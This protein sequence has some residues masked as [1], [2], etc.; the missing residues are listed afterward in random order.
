MKK[1]PHQEFIENN[2]IDINSLPKMLQK[3][4]NGFDEL[5]NDLQHTTEHDRAQLV[6][7]LETLSHEIQEDLD[8]EFEDQLEN[9]DAEE[10]PTAVPKK[11]LAAKDIQ[12]EINKPVK[13]KD[14]KPSGN[15]AILEKMYAEKQ[16]TISPEQLIQ[17]GFKVPLDKKIIVGKY[18]LSRG[19]YDKCY[20]LIIAGK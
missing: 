7:K 6:D 19:K 2:L 20:Q 1:Y 4:I 5:E 10:E 18:S 14:V 3:R 12:V 13:D 16:L 17:K 8:E 9:N 15:E 11:E